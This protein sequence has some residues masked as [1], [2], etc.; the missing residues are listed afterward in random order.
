MSPLGTAMVRDAAE[1][2]EAGDR[3]SSDR[4]RVIELFATDWHA[5]VAGLLH[6]THGMSGQVAMDAALAKLA[7]I[8]LVPASFRVEYTL[9]L[10]TASFEVTESS[11]DL[12]EAY[13]FAAEASA[14]E[15]LCPFA[16]SLRL[17]IA[18][19]FGVRERL[20]LEPAAQSLMA[21]GKTAR[22]T[23][24]AIAARAAASQAAPVV[25]DGLET[26]RLARAGRYVAEIVHE[27][28]NPATALVGYAEASR[29]DFS[30]YANVARNAVESFAL[31]GGNA[32]GDVQHQA[33]LQAMLPELAIRAE[34]SLERLNAAA[35]RL[36]RR[37]A[38]SLATCVRVRPTRRP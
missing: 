3:I 7:R 36:F 8:L 6:E 19:S 22:L 30:A 13:V 11:V 24:A 14:L 12:A 34:H 9:G 31:G 27:L 33:R 28:G 35:T 37:P 23:L 1:K 29:R 10:A 2:Q 26:R 16:R 32:E 18:L 15:S 5:E 20:E 17:T 38:I 25:G 21:F 4:V